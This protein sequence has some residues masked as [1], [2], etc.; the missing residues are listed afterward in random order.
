MITVVFDD[1]Y[2]F[3]RPLE[4]QLTSFLFPPEQMMHAAQEEVAYEG[5]KRWAGWANAE[6]SS[7][8]ASWN[9]TAYSLSHFLWKVSDDDDALI[10]SENPAELAH[11]PPSTA[12]CAGDCA[13]G[14]ECG[15]LSDFGIPPTYQLPG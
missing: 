2:F 4:P 9:L 10:L 13:L 14:M 5:Q 1:V 6:M 7:Q 8:N 15:H 3:S 12:R 11:L